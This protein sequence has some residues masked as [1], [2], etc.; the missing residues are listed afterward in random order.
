MKENPKI[1]KQSIRQV[2][3]I[4]I[5]PEAPQINLYNKERYFVQLPTG[6]FVMNNSTE[7]IM[8]GKPRYVK[9]ANKVTFQSPILANEAARFFQSKG[10]KAVV[11]EVNFEEFSI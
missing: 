11:N 1:D 3:I 6:E 4:D 9:T 8:K 5:D 7:E 10:I 2:Q